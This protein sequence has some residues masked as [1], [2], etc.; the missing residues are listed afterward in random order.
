MHS[1]IPTWILVVKKKKVKFFV[2]SSPIQFH[3]LENLICQLNTQKWGINVTFGHRE[4]NFIATCFVFTEEKNSRGQCSDIWRA[5]I[6]DLF[7]ARR[8]NGY[9]CFSN[10]DFFKIY[11]ERSKSTPIGTINLYHENH[12]NTCMTPPVR[13]NLSFIF[14]YRMYL[15]I[16]WRA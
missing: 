12:E 4:L 1:S 8:G 5:G 10:S 2:R 13:T 15:N 16:I 14:N 9:L 7:I 3:N 6:A 11:N